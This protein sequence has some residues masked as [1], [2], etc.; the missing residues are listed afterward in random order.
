[1]RESWLKALSELVR[2]LVAECDKA[3]KSGIYEKTVNKHAVLL[4]IVQLPFCISSTKAA[5]KPH[6]LKHR[7]RNGRATY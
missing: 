3:W 5:Q 4:V 6:A 7:C 1:M 2:R